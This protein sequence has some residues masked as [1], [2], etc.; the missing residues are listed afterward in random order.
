MLEART[1]QR[2]TGPGSGRAQ[3][4]DAVRHASAAFTMTSFPNRRIKPAGNIRPA[5]RLAHTPLQN[6]RE[7]RITVARFSRGHPS[8]NRTETLSDARGVKPQNRRT[9]TS[10]KVSAVA[11][12]QQF[13]FSGAQDVPPNPTLPAFKE[14]C[15]KSSRRDRRTTRRTTWRPTA[16]NSVGGPSSAAIDPPSPVKRTPLTKMTR[17]ALIFILYKQLVGNIGSADESVIRSL[18]GRKTAFLFSSQ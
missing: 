16:E 4:A 14:T 12:K 2:L 3:P 17:V 10:A 13:P 1:F 18:G 9:D 5:R 6:D 7:N 11:P 15:G 8:R